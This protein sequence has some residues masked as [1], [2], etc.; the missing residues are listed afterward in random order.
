MIGASIRRTSST[1]L[2]VAGPSE[3][4]AQLMSMTIKQLTELLHFECNAGM[5]T[6]EL[7][8]PSFSLL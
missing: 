3:D 4:R 6:D 1:S 7:K 2:G 5:L 8:L